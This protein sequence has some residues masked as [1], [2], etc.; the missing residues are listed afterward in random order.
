M[1]LWKIL[2]VLLIIISSSKPHI[3]P[4]EVLV[5]SKNKIKENE[6][7]S[8]KNLI[9]DKELNNEQLFGQNTIRNYVFGANVVYFYLMKVQTNFFWREQSSSIFSNKTTKLQP[10]KC[11]RVLFISIKHEWKSFFLWTKCCKFYFYF[12][13][14]RARTW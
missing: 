10:S 11:R 3:K 1:F 12:L 8:F 2:I 4:K 9:N 5:N 6:S 7:N 13:E 14:R